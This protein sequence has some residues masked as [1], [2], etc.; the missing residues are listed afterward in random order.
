MESYEYRETG[1]NN[2]LIDKE[3]GLLPGFALGLG[4][5]CN[6]WEFAVRGV[7]QRA[8]LEY[9][10]QTNT[11]RKFLSRTLES[12]GD[13][14]AQVERRFLVSDTNSVGVYGGVGYW[15]WRRNI[16][17]GGN[18]SGL[19]EKY[20]WRY[21]YLGSNVA[22]IEQK[23]HQ[24][25]LDIRWLRLTQAKLSVDF[26]GVFDKPE[27][28]M[29]DVRNGWR[30]ALPWQYMF[31]PENSIRLEPYAQGWRIPRSEAKFLSRNGVIAGNFFEPASQTRAYGIKAT[32]SHWF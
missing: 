14:S 7:Q 27:D 25:R 20:R 30:V 8:R 11:G 6:Q 17:S 2:H 19:D 18:V 28:L 9:D 10:G 21:Y 31:N 5:N 23:P 24:L 32:W 1:N 13:L 22:L 16:A 15:Q 4:A 26:L 3:D 12:I 29:L